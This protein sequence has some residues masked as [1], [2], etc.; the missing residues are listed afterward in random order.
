MTLGRPTRFSTR[1]S[2]TTS[3]LPFF[4]GAKGEGVWTVAGCT[5]NLTLPL[6]SGDDDDRVGGKG[7]GGI[8]IHGDLLGRGLAR[9]AAHAAET[10]L[11]FSVRPRHV[12]RRVQLIGCELT[13][14]PIASPSPSPPKPQ[15]LQRCSSYGYPSLDTGPRGGCMLPRTIFL[16]LFKPRQPPVHPQVVPLHSWIVVTLSSRLPKHHWPA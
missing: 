1:P 10:V 12:L 6:V 5:P 4:S 13:R 2:R 7:T 8:V 15:I 3:F 16:E 11:P 9:L 14:P